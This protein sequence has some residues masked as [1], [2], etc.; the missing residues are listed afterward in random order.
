M[1]ETFVIECV[2]CK[3]WSWVGTGPVAGH[4]SSYIARSENGVSTLPRDGDFAVI[5]SS[6]QALAASPKS[7][8]AISEDGYL[9]AQPFPGKRT[10]STVNGKFSN[11]AWG[12]SIIRVFAPRC[13]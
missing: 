7:P 3:T 10:S 9:E 8:S 12:D 13:S 6:Q 5:M 2:A 1:V 11:F 4:F